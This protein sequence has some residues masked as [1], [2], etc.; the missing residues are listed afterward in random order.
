MYNY[1]QRKNV[2]EKDSCLLECVVT[3]EFL[4]ICVLFC[5]FCFVIMQA[6]STFGEKKSQARDHMFLCNFKITSELF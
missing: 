2:W 4:S 5:F 6:P 3:P 1:A